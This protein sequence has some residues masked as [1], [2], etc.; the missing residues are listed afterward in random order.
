MLTLLLALSFSWLAF[1]KYDSS[2]HRGIIKLESVAV[3]SAPLL[4]AP[5]ILQIYG[6]LEVRI[7]R[8]QDGWLQIEYPGSIAGWVEPGSV[9]E[10]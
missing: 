5:E 6:G 3:R 8:H 2:L 7:L 1:F 4:T 10:L 9:V